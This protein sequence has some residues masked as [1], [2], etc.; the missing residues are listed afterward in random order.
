MTA[1]VKMTALGFNESAIRRLKAEKKRKMEELQRDLEAIDRVETMLNRNSLPMRPRSTRVDESSPRT[2][3]RDLV[4]GIVGKADHPLFP[5]EIVKLAMEQ[6]Y[7]FKSD[8]NGLGSIT[9]VLSRK[10]GKGVHKLSDGR[11]TT[12]KTA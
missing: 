12:E 6:G 9:S 11:W 1:V 7:P 2:R 5:Q 3:L 4:L 8:R 10:K